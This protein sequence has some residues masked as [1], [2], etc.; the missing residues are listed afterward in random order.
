[1]SWSSEGV[2]RTIEGVGGARL[3]GAYGLDTLMQTLVDSRRMLLAVH[4]LRSIFAFNGHNWASR[5]SRCIHADRH[6]IF[7]WP[8]LPGHLVAGGRR[9]KHETPVGYFPSLP[10]RPNVNF[11]SRYSIANK[12]RD[13]TKARIVQS[14]A[15]HRPHA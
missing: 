11:I 7:A 13:P 6:A 8:G 10:G 3:S 1:M 15:R 4:Q 5:D 12:N 9:I 2:E 14:E